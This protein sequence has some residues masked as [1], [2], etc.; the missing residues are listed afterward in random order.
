MKKVK[1]NVEELFSSYKSKDV[2]DNCEIIQFEDC[3]DEIDSTADMLENEPMN[4]TES[5]LLKRNISTVLETLGIREQKL[6]K[7]IYGIGLKDGS[8]VKA[9]ADVFDVSCERIIQI[10]DRS[11]RKLRH[12]TRSII[13]D[14]DT[15]IRVFKKSV[16][17]IIPHVITKDERKLSKHWINND[18]R[19]KDKIIQIEQC[20]EDGTYL[21]CDEEDWELP[22]KERILDYY[23]QQ[24]RSDFGSIVLL[25]LGDEYL[26]QLKNEFIYS[27]G[28]ENFH[29]RMHVILKR[30]SEQKINNYVNNPNLMIRYYIRRLI[31]KVY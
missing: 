9:T 24:L 22:I 25:K 20:I 5:V 14:T 12:P 1:S 29:K 2:L 6:M 15:L 11:L 8:T 19:K 16:P 18:I 21:S 23:L 7:C 31:K 10:R 4:L 17:P 26:E 28:L 30:R 27:I 13:L 3:I